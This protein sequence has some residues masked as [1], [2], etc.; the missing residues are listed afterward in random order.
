MIKRKND[1]ESTTAQTTD[2]SY[3]GTM[4]KVK[5]AEMRYAANVDEKLRQANSDLKREKRR[6][7]IKQIGNKLYL[8]ATLPLKNGDSNKGKGLKQYDIALK[9]S[10]NLEGV[11]T[12][13]ESAYKLSADLDRN[14]FKWDD[15]VETPDPSEATR[16][17]GELLDKFEDEYFKKQH[18][19][20]KRQRYFQKYRVSRITRHCDLSLEVNYNNFRDCINRVPTPGAKKGLLVALKLLS[21]TFNLQFNFED[22]KIDNSYTERSIPSDK[23]IEANFLLFEKK[24][25]NRVKQPKMELRNTWRLKAWCYGMLAVFGLRP[26]ELLTY[27]DIN[28]WLS[29]SNVDNTW[30]VHKDCKTGAR[31]VF[32]LNCQWIEL[33]DLKNPDRLTELQAWAE[34]LTKS[35]QV[36]Y[37]VQN[38]AQ[39]FK[40]C[41]IEHQPYDLRH[42]WAI[43]AHLLG[44]PIKAAADNLGHGVEIHTKTY[45]RWFG[46]E[47]RKKAIDT[48]IIKK[49]ENELM[50]DEIIQLKLEN[51]RLKIENERLKLNM[52]FNK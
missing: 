16:T 41:N 8:R 43:R 7:S 27:P 32:P 14:T 5:D 21:S 49:S 35:E 4:A 34:K 31:E 45:Q 38:I 48:A 33:F 12:A 23:E 20:E 42:A 6:C 2:G 11:K 52:Q 9:V 28:W 18:L 46:R 24:S 26:H 22:I 51:E 25:L 15:W 37:A 47:N 30:K 29:S 17:I 10:A 1:D 3:R 40:R 44:I 19:T 13:T 50:K 36:D 39:F